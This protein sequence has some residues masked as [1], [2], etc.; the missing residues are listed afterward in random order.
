MSA[1]DSG[2]SGLPVLLY[3][4]ASPDAVRFRPSPVSGFDN[5]HSGG[6]LRGLV[7]AAVFEGAALLLLGAVWYMIAHAR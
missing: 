3:P 5:A 1:L 2:P 7:W 6:S 4:K